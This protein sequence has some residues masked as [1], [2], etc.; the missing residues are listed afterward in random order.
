MSKYRSVI[1]VKGE[2]YDVLLTKSSVRG[3]YLMKLE[4]TGQL[5]AQVFKMTWRKGNPWSCTS[6]LRSTPNKF[7]RV[8]G[9]RTL[10]DCMDW[11]KSIAEYE[12][13]GNGL[14]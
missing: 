4:D 2:P 11:I 13:I 8:D 5:L 12:D 3:S 9:F 1:W 10:E 14:L 7:N 6:W